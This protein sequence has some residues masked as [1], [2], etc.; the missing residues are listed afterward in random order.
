MIKKIIIITLFVV[1]FSLIITPIITDYLYNIKVEQLE[2]KYNENTKDKKD[3]E[4]LNKLLEEENK[5]IYNDKQASFLYQEKY[6]EKNLI[7]LSKYGIEDEIF[8]FIE[9]PSIEIKLPLYL[10]ANDSN[11]K[12]GAV[13]LTGT[14]YP[15]GGK[16]T[17]SVIAAHRGY[18]K[19]LMFRNI[20][21]IKIGDILY[22]KN[23]KETLEYKAIKTDIID[24]SNL[25]KLKI[26]ENKDMVTIISCHPFPYNYQRYVV[27]FQR[28]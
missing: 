23:Y 6:F 7:D 10:G 13:H 14:S 3:Y 28:V 11:M 8:G 21:K 27:Y 22:I 19:T 2:K 25:D 18:Y 9:I 26:I 24:P 15:I 17:N 1:G 12:K 4:A 5:K 16:N 20:N